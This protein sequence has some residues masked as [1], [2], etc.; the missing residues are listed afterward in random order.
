MRIAHVAKCISMNQIVL[1]Q[2]A[3][4]RARGHE[5][6]ALC[7]DEAEWT[8]AIKARGIQVI[9]VPYHGHSKAAACVAALKTWFACLTR[10]FDV[11]HTHNALPGVTGR[12][13]ARLAG[14]PVVLH[15]WH[16]WPARLPRPWYV[17]L[18]FALL[19]PLATA[20]A[21]AVLFLNPDD[22]AVWSAMRGV[23][24]RKARL[25]GNGINV[26]EFAQRLQTGARSRI[27]REFGIGEDS[28]LL[29]K[30]ARMEHPRKGHFFLLEGLKRFRELSRREVAALLV[31]AGDDEEVVRAEAKRLGLEDVVRFPGYRR[32]IPDILAAADVSVLT[33]PFEGV[34]RALMESMALG[35]PVLG[36]DVPGTRMLV[37]P[38]ES[39]MLVR[40]GD[41][42]G[43]AGALLQL[44]E[45]PALAKRLGEGGR[46]RVR[47]KFN[48]PDVAARILRIYEHSL[49]ERGRPLP[50]F[51]VEAES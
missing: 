3:H 41:V 38:G 47:E 2:M 12:I 43:L 16:S 40:Q 42:E 31:G 1:N 32:D 25:I 37:R 15:T 6:F 14:V 11:V 33:S 26:E 7:P 34:P 13:A 29:V 39:G 21:D 50:H 20:A 19:E 22:L 28:Y 36:T 5:V 9:D 24:V 27:R 48:E 45:D 17:M 23:A 4:Q 18:G 44:S 35:V 49:N 10:R 51:D 8:E 30:V 46:R